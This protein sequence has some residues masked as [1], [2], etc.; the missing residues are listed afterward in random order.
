MGRDMFMVV[1]CNEGY[2]RSVANVELLEDL[3]FEEGFEVR[4]R[5]LHLR[6]GGSRMRPTCPRDALNCVIRMRCANKI[7]V[8]SRRDG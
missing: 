3:L 4:K 1:A 5:H 7:C 8:G 2:Q 6:G